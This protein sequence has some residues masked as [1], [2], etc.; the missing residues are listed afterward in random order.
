M[1]DPWALN[2]CSSAVRV[3]PDGGIEDSGIEDS[4]IEDGRLGTGLDPQ[5]ARFS[6]RNGI[7]NGPR[8]REVRSG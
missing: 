5:Q 3:S 2:A 6:S 7:G 4:G 1:T 8:S